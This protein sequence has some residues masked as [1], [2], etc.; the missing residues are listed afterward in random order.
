MRQKHLSKNL[1]LLT[2]ICLKHK[3]TINLELQ[4][5][6]YKQLQIMFIQHLATVSEFQ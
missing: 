3:I 2:E 5:I 1:Y 6:A 4:G